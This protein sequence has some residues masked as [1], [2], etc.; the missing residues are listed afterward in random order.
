G[1][2]AV[3]LDAGQNF[4]GYE[5]L[6]TAGGPA[7]GAGRP[8]R[9]DGP[10][11]LQIR[12]G[13]QVLRRGEV[14]VPARPLRLPARPEGDRLSVQGNDLAPLV[15]YDPFPADDPEAVFALHWP[16]GVGLTRLVA[17]RL[18]QPPAVSP[19]ENGDGLFAAGRFSEAL[20]EYE[21]QAEAARGTQ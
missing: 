9:G 18:A 19:L 4:A 1:D 21:R 10:L 7:A 15:F 2:Q 17:Q 6:L 14:E 11:Q 12:R 5:F 8:L 3:K 20:P 13:G 16:A